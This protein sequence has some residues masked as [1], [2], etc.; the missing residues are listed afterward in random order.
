MDSKD[1]RFIIMHLGA[2]SQNIWNT[3][4]SSKEM[5][6]REDATVIR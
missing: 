1:F 4:M 5:G 3:L 2:Y 6:V